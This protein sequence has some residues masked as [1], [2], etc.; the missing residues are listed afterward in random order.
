MNTINYFQ[1]VV[2]KTGA[3]QAD[4]FMRLFMAPGMQHC[5]NGPGPDNFGQM[6]TSD[7]I[8]PAT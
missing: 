1:S 2:A 6:V 5:N 7:A 4:S 8:R 3:R